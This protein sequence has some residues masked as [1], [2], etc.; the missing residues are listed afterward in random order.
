MHN[1]SSL[2]IVQKYILLATGTPSSFAMR[3]SVFVMYEQT[4]GK[5]Q[6]AGLIDDF[7]TDVAGK[8]DKGING[9]IQDIAYNGFG[10]EMADHE[11]GRLKNDLGSQGINSWSK[12][13]AYS[14]IELEGELGATLDNRGEAANLFTDKLAELNSDSVYKGPQA[15]FA[16]REWLVSIGSTDESFATGTGEIRDLIDSFH[17]HRDDTPPELTFSIPLDGATDF[18]TDGFIIFEFNEPVILDEG[19][20]VISNGH[21]IRTIDVQEDAGLIRVDGNLIIIDPGADL[22]ANTV[23][24]ISFEGEH[25]HEHEHGNGHKQGHEHGNG[26][27][28]GHEHGHGHDHDDDDDDDYDDHHHKDKHGHKHKDKHDHKDKHKHKDKH[29]HKDEHEHRD[30]HDHRYVHGGIITDL[31]GNAYVGPMEFQFAT[32]AA[33]DPFLI[34][35]VPFAKETAFPVDG[36]FTLVFNELVTAGSGDIVISNSVDAAD[37]RVIAVGDASQVIFDGNS[38]WFVPSNSASL[39]RLLPP[40][41]GKSNMNIARSL[42]VGETFTRAGAL[43]DE[44]IQLEIPASGDIVLISNETDMLILNPAGAL[45]T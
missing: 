10:L 1:S 7:M 28:Q 3:E 16:A 20:V 45:S 15:A 2:V 18:Q 32:I 22:E 11:V 29:D 39:W 44:S 25:T 26:H 33:V 8:H 6:V 42:S 37:T 43:R 40:R 21:D 19:V 27:K 36:D 34:D 5:N 41:Y 38:V 9:V 24:N 31:A 4:N 12:L 30:E 35:S 17:N 23:Y 14:A 13:F